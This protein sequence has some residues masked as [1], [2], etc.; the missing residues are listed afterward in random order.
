[1]KKIF[2]A[3]IA[4]VLFSSHVMYL[5]LEGYFLEPNT[6]AT[7]QLFNGTFDKS[8]NV[9]DR[10]RMLDA[11]LLGN[12]QR[13]KVAESQWSEKDSVT[14]LNFKTGEAGTWVAGISTA[15]RAIEMDAD[16]FNTYLEHEGI[17]DMIDWRHENNKMDSSAVEKYSKHVKT[18]FQ[19]GDK[20][21]DDWQKALG[22]P[23]EFV[24]LDNPYELNTGDT[25][26]IKL[27]LNG[28]PLANQ[29]VYANFKAPEDGHTHGTETGAEHT[30]TDAG[31]HGLSHD[32]KKEEA[33]D[34][35][36]NPVQGHAHEAKTEDKHTHDGETTQHSHK[37]ETSEA[38]E[39]SHTHKD[40]STSHTH[41]EE[42]QAKHSHSVD[43]A[44][45]H[46]ND[47]K[48]DIEPH[49][50]TSGQ[51]MRTDADGVI[52]V[53]LSADGIWYVQTIHL[54]ETDE[55]N[56]THES[57]W[58]TLTFEVVHAHGEDTHTHEEGG[59]PSYVYWILSVLLIGLLFFWFNR[60]N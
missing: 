32:T 6:A 2:I 51:Q 46:D 17:L 47:T 13:I 58:T 18:I 19:V 36:E 15:P 26:R 24:P 23:I 27:L 43:E 56:Y 59:I 21:S 33:H 11:S 10:D 48:D 12:G 16:A 42:T 53:S 4:F 31:E 9:I 50:H 52:E 34:H 54:V 22:Y 38:N 28:A 41:A 14:V 30:H 57:N 20:K 39:H 40:G 35:D 7:I 55:E 44:H 25:L 45:E 37:T 29:L 60:K 3:L 8:E 1:M 5:K 49:T